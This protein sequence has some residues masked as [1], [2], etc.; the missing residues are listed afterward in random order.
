MSMPSETDQDLAKWALLQAQIDQVRRQ[1]RWETPKA[2]AMIALALAAIVVASR[3]TDLILP[4]RPQTIVVRLDQ[5]IAV[6]LL[7]P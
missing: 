1:A 4:P 6:R 2:V 7:P 5:P 3:L